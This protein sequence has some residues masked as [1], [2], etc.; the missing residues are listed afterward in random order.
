MSI[1]GPAQYFYT[2]SESQYP[3]GPHFEPWF[4][5]TV[6]G[7]VGALVAIIASCAFVYLKH[8][9]YR[10]LYVAIIM[11]NAIM[12]APN[13][14]LFSRL[15]V[16]WGISDYW[17]VTLD[18]AFQTGIQ[19]MFYSPGLLLLSRVSPDQ[20]E[21]SMFAILAANTNLA[22]T[23]TGPISGFIS[24]QFGITPDGSYNESH[25]FENMWKANILM[26]LI[27][28]IPLAFVWLLPNIK[29][30]EPLDNVRIDVSRDSPLNRL[31]ALRRN[32]R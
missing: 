4:F 32:R 2:D 27:K 3:E 30:S 7:I 5:V 1:S 6:C 9:K 10:S 14:I 13:S 25:K 16:K 20:L 17:F 26:S 24:Q 21:S 31:F 28:L 12:S 23:I 29:L 22:S 11:M 18:T 15:N 8:A 19:A